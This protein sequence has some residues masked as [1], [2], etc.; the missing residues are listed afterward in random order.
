MKAFLNYQYGFAQAITA[1]SKQTATQL[2]GR[3]KDTEIAENTVAKSYIP[4]QFRKPSFDKTQDDVTEFGSAV[5]LVM[6]YL[7]YKACN[8]PEQ[9][10]LQIQQLVD[11]GYILEEI[12]EKIDPEMLYGFFESDLGQKCVRAENLLREFKFSVL[13]DADR[14]Y[15][16]CTG[17]K[18]LLQGVVDCAIIEDDGII[19]IDFKTDRVTENTID[20]VT[21]Q[22]RMQV[23]AYSDALSRIYDKPVK[24]A[25][26][27]FFKINK[28]IAV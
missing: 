20:Q 13:V 14:Y 6:Q 1:P 5:H 21:D 18:V 19:V 10:K 3:Q 16:G 12:G 15:A 28:H 26:L 27:H 7:D 22:Y 2:K 17:D 8:D 23:Q 11:E 4:L 25:Y 24:A 9:I